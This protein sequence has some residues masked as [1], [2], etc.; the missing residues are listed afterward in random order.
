MMKFF[1]SILLL[2]SMQDLKATAYYVS[3]GGNDENN[4]TSPTA[5]WRTLEKVQAAANKGLLIAGDSILFK[6]GDVFTGTLKWAT[7]WG[8]NCATGTPSK[9]ITFTTYGVGNKPVFQYPKGGTTIPENRIT[10]LFSGVDY[11]IIDGFNFTELQDTGNDKITPANCGVPIYLGTMDEATTNHCTIRNVDI[12]YCGMGIVIVGNYNKV[13]HCRMT[14]FKNLKSTPNTGGASEYDDYGANALTITGDDNEISYNYISGAWAGS[15][16]FGWNGGACEMFNHC[17][18]NV[19]SHNT[20]YD[21]GGVAEFGGQRKDAFSEDNLFAYNKIINC[22]SLTWCNISG[23]F[24]IRVSNVQ[25]FNNTIIENNT[26][27]F[28]GPNTG[29]G[30]TDPGLLSLI[31][32]EESLFAFN[33]SPDATTVFNLRNNVFHLSTGIAVVKNGTDLSKISHENNMY[34]LKGGSAVNFKLA[35]SETSSEVPLFKD[36]V[37]ANPLEWNLLLHKE[38]SIKNIGAEANPIGPVINMAAGII[39][40]DWLSK[41][42][43]HFGTGANI[44]DPDFSVSNIRRLVSYLVSWIFD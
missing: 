31:K 2:F 37:S 43:L 14:D 4:G 30:I 42:I 23:V 41:Y 28:S 18:R 13:T 17:N 1:A 3:N 22:G 8:Q 32:P 34:Y 35:T 44:A 5:S 25:Y 16:D 40:C 9:P 33:G 38:A 12:S 20:I 15:A 27:R 36:T 21:C 19:I 24:S 7:I 11:I 10:L 39:V 26:S 6:R 29:K